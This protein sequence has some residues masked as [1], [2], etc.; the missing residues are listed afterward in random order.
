M[1]VKRLAGVYLAVI[2]AAVAIHFVADPL[3]YEW[4][5]GTPTLWIVLDW[6]MAVGLAI[7][8]YVTF[9]AKQAADGGSDLREYLVANT[10]FFVAAGPDA[11]LPLERRPDLVGRGRADAGLAGMGV[12]RR[13]GADAVR[14]ARHRPLERGGGVASSLRRVRHTEGAPRGAPSLDRCGRRW[15]V[16]RRV[17]DGGAVLLVAG[18]VAGRV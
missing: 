16:L 8:L 18:P 12:H 10:K 2:G 9:M 13:G 4:D 5:D 6:L 14:H 1:M 15:G 3:V 17:A 7:A 11:A